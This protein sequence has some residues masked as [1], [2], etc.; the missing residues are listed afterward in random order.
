MTSARPGC[1]GLG[2]EGLEGFRVQ[3][4]GDFGLRV[5]WVRGVGGHFFGWGFGPFRIRVWA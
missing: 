2:H 4:L 3:G 5:L 1:R